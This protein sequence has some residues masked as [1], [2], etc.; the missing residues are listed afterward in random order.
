NFNDNVSVINPVTNH[1]VAVIHVGIEPY[2]IAYDPATNSIYTANFNGG[3]ITA[4]NP[5]TNSTTG[6]V[7][8]GVGTGPDQLAYDPA[9]QQLY[10]TLFGMHSVVALDPTTSTS[11]TIET[12]SFPLGIAYDP[13]NFDMYVA[14]EGSDNVSVISSAADAV[15]ATLPVGTAPWGVAYDG[16][17]HD[18]MVTN[19]GSNNVTILNNATTFKG[20][21]WPDAAANIGT[22]V[23]PRGIAYDSY[24]HRVFVAN[25]HTTPPPYFSGSIT[26]FGGESFTVTRTVSFPQGNAAAFAYDPANKDFYVTSFDVG[27]VVVSATTYK[28]VATIPIDPGF[29]SGNA[30]AYDPATKQ[31]FVAGLLYPNVSVINGTTNRIVANISAPGA[32]AIAYD[33]IDR[34]MFITTSAPSGSGNVS[35]ING[36]TDQVVQNTSLPYQPDSIGYDPAD[37]D[38]FVGGGT[39]NVTVL[40]ATTD[41]FI[42][43]LTAGSLPFAITYDPANGALYVANFGSANVTIIDSGSLRSIGS[44]TL[45]LFQGNPNP[46]RGVGYD[47]NDQALFVGGESWATEFNGAGEMIGQTTSISIL[48]ADTPVYDPVTH[49]MIVGEDGYAYFTVIAS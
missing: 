11:V 35:E 23:G 46:A 13:A 4:I 38:L 44:L 6:S 24:H 39:N 17:D 29:F 43:N 31:V 19:E 37:Q 10:V 26:Y 30:L 21:Q 9:N 20:L 16:Q 5:L 15:V 22:D 34:A 25:W 8:L 2:G 32:N 18:M 28:E 45:P 14:N 36:T 47:P 27:V 41:A 12:G 3:D 1:V 49:A 48:Q 42:T 40:N 7:F 33:P